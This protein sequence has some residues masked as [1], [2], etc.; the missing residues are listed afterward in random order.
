MVLNPMPCCLMHRFRAET[1][2]AAGRGSEIGDYLTTHPLVNC[3]SF[4]GGDTGDTSALRSL[5]LLCCAVLLSGSVAGVLHC[6]RVAAGL[7]I[8][9]KAGMVPIQVR[10]PA[11][12]RSDSPQAHSLVSAAVHVLGCIMVSSISMGMN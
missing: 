1:I 8:C 5:L 11:F 6:L 9:K 10:C 2:L 3:I 4:T 12:I 7:S